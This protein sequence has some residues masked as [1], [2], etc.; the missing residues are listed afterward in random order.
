MTNSVRVVALEE[1]DGLLGYFGIGLSRVVTVVETDAENAGGDDWCEQLRNIR[2]ALQ[3]RNARRKCRRRF[4]DRR[5]PPP[6]R[7]ERCG[8]LN[9]HSGQVSWAETNSKFEIRN[10]NRPS[11]ASGARY[12][13][14]VCNCRRIIL[15]EA[16]IFRGRRLL[17]PLIAMVSLGMPRCFGSNI[18]LTTARR[19]PMSRCCGGTARTSRYRRSLEKSSCRWPGWTA[20]MGPASAQPPLARRRFLRS[21]VGRPRSRPYRPRQGRR[22]PLPPP[23][24]RARALR[25]SRPPF[26]EAMQRKPPSQLPSPGLRMSIAGTWTRSCWGTPSR[27][28]LDRH[29][30]QRSAQPL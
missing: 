12:F 23:P 9:L 14:R 29:G 13:R 7:R 26:P 22:H 20:S 5:R 21:H 3:S 1:K 24:L 16:V 4:C 30:G 8:D 28:L 10:S 27:R 18:R 25:R 2:P 11:M 6:A 17:F 19:T 15:N